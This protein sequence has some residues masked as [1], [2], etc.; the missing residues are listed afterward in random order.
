MFPFRIRKWVAKL[1]RRQPRKGE[2][3]PSR[4][5]KWGLYGRQLSFL[6]L[7]AGCFPSP[8]S[9]STQVDARGRT[10]ALERPASRVV[11]LL[12]SLTE[13]LFALDQGHLVVGRTNWCRFPPEAQSIAVVGGLDSPVAESILQLNPDIIL[14]GPFLRDEQVVHLESLNLKVATFDHQNWATIVRD[15]R[16]LGQIIDREEDAQ[17][18]IGSLDERRRTIMAQSGEGG[19]D[20]PIRTLLLYSLEPLYSCGANTFLHEWIEAAGGHNIAA[21]SASPWPMLSLESV[22]AKQPEVL[23]VSKEGGNLEELIEK[24]RGLPQDPI[25]GQ[26]NAVRNNR[27]FL[28]DG[29]TLAVPGPRLLSALEQ[30][31]AALQPEIFDA[32]PELIHLDLKDE[33]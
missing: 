31:A 6:L 20:K 16:L 7:G 13:Y 23:L 3:S 19:R 2:S 12:P 25:W 11:S 5:R 8:S 22:L 14:A 21:D 29:D 27:I 1:C 4:W 15:L 17:N 9:G 18:L 30:I 33:R 28:L 26:L 32:P 24:I 10:V